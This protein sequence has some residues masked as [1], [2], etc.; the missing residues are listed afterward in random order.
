M[1]TQP[2]AAGVHHAGLAQHRQQLGPALDRLLAGVERA[3]EQL[4][5][6]RVLLVG[7]RLSSV[8]RVCGMWASSVA[9]RCAISRTTVRIVPSAG[10][11]TEP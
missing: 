8:S 11:R 7:V 2:V 10:A 6:Q 4:G 5:Q 3:L 9:M 1:I